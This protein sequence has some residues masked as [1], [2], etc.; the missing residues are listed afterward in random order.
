[1]KDEE[2]MSYM[3]E[4]IEAMLSK[5]ELLLL[6]K[7]YGFKI[8]KKTKIKALKRGVGNSFEKFIQDNRGAWVCFAFV[9]I[10]PPYENVPLDQFF[11]ESMEDERSE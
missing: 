4:E 5:R 8:D 11:R 9:R 6:D 1:M 3:M 7:V 2:V 10:T